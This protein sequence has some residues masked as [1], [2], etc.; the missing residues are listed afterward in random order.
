MTLAN[1]ID[2]LQSSSILGWKKMNYIAPE[3]LQETYSLISEILTSLVN[4]TIE[5]KNKDTKNKIDYRIAPSCL[6]EFEV[7]TKD[8]VEKL[9]FGA[10]GFI[11]DFIVS[12]VHSTPFQPK[13]LDFFVNTSEF[14]E[15]FSYLSEFYPLE[16][17][18]D[19]PK[20]S[21]VD[22]ELDELS[23]IGFINN[24]VNKWDL[25]GRKLKEKFPDCK[26]KNIQEDGG[27]RFSDISVLYSFSYKGYPIELIFG[28]DNRILNFDISF[29]CA[30][31]TSS[32]IYINELG[33][34]D[35]RNKVIRIFHQGTPIS[36]L[37][38]VLD[39]K[40]RMN[41]KMDQIS[42][43]LLL[44]TLNSIK[45]TTTDFLSSFRSHKKYTEQLEAELYSLPHYIE[46]MEVIDEPYL[47]S[48]LVMEM[49]TTAP[50][51]LNIEY[52]IFTMEHLSDYNPDLRHYYERCS[53]VLE[54]NGSIIYNKI[55]SF[56]TTIKSIEISSYVRPENWYTEDIFLN[57]IN[58]KREFDK[59]LNKERLI[60]MFDIRENKYSHSNELTTQ[61]LDMMEQL[62]RENELGT[63]ENYCDLDS[64]YD[65]LPV[66]CRGK[67]LRLN[68]E[69]TDQL[70]T[71][72]YDNLLQLEVIDASGRRNPFAMY[73]DSKNKLVRVK[74]FYGINDY[75]GL[76]GDLYTDFIE[77]LKNNLGFTDYDVEFLVHKED[78]GN[79]NHF[80]STT[81]IDLIKEANT[82][83]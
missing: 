70:E 11:S 7:N 32:G 57:S 73:I 56:L 54:R 5:K 29:R 25:V 72:L 62:I 44:S 30:Y 10:G 68:F 34:D 37:I 38:R 63:I 27:Y 76:V 26:W 51:F 61:T 8:R 78:N 36:T 80:W 49:S 35:I 64:A 4:E 6:S 33:L 81:P 13:D 20:D 66:I 19:L 74:K 28:H 42:L 79:L 50:M 21:N 17:E 41:F 46:K 15:I 69:T 77:Q 47:V 3:I 16:N 75:F 82:K 65:Y 9:I 2:A 45:L 71:L 14:E 52:M 83:K 48:D 59:W 58:Y 43:I 18:K 24:Y 1:A 53:K 40:K 39:F 23:F 67:E 12:K 22:S 31:Y 55:I 60:A